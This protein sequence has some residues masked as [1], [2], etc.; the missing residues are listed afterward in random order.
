LQE[1]F[2][3]VAPGQVIR[4]GEGQDLEVVSKDSHIDCRQ[5]LLVGV[6]NAKVDIDQGAEIDDNNNDDTR[7]SE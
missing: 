5:L 3:V 6:C 7:E 2:H 4:G 1:L